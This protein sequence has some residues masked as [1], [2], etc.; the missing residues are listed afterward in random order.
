MQYQDALTSQQLMYQNQ[1][2]SSLI[3]PYSAYT[4][5]GYTGLG[6]GSAGYGSGYGTGYGY[7]Y[8]GGISGGLNISGG[9]GF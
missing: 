7:G 2:N 5:Y 3:N 1:Y 6:Y 8:S 4:N 9:I